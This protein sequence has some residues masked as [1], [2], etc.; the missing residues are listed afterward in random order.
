MIGVRAL[1]ATHLIELA[2]RIADIEAAVEGD[3]RVISL[4][5]GVQETPDNRVAPTFKITSGAPLGSSY[6]REIARRHGIS[7]DQILAAR[8][9]PDPG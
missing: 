6:A 1:Y 5:A 2:S 9:K 3:S 4:V 7:L 8:T